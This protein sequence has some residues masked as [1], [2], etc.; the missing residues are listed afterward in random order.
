MLQEHG[1]KIIII[2]EAY[3]SLMLI[4]VDLAIIIIISS[5]NSIPE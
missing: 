3:Y 1:H 2:M 4:M 5:I